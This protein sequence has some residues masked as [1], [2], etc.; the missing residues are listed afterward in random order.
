M[1]VARSTTAI[2]TFDVA[3]V[4][5][6]RTRRMSASCSFARRRRAVRDITRRQKPARSVQPPY[7]ASA[8]TLGHAATPALIKRPAA[9]TFQNVNGRTAAMIGC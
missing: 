8:T 1:S 7:A 4:R 6:I 3:Q 5:T 9:L 2:R